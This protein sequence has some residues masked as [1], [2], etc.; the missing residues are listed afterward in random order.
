MRAGST[1]GC[2]W[3]SCS[4]PTGTRA[5]CSALGH[6][7]SPPRP[8]R[9]PQPADRNF[10]RCRVLCDVPA[11]SATSCRPLRRGTGQC[12]EESHAIA[13]AIELTGPGA[14]GGR[15]AAAGHGAHLAHGRPARGREAVYE[16]AVVVARSNWATAPSQLA[17]GTQFPGP[18]APRQP[19]GWTP[20]TRCTGEVICS[21][22]S[23]TGR[24]RQRRRRR[25]SIC[26]MLAITRR[27]GPTTRSRLAAARCRPSSS[28]RWARKPIGAKPDRGAGRVERR[29]RHSGQALRTAGGCGARAMGGAPPG[30]P[31]RRARTMSFLAATADRQ[32]T[33]QQ[34]PAPAAFDAAELED[35]GTQDATALQ[36]DVD[37]RAGPAG[38]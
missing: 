3:C 27:A 10:G 38:C 21:W 20:Q 28:R 1:R 13:V 33:G 30:M 23:A 24:P 12:L 2:S 7:A 29:T 14:H 8:W 9:A 15:A 37:G 11:S 36:Q 25:C 16:E 6:C 35:A 34:L 22:P 17:V 19:G 18:A 32:R 5:A 26:A 31:P 4:R